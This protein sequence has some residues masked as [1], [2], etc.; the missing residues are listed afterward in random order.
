MIRRGAHPR[1]LVMRFLRAVLILVILAVLGTGDAPIASRVAALT[2]RLAS[3]PVPSPVAVISR[4]P[5]QIR[6]AA[7]DS[8]D[9]DVIL[10]LVLLFA[11][12]RGLRAP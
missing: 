11:V 2:A 3:A 10:G 1:G 12:Q 9:E 4:R 8:H 7:L 5:A 6:R